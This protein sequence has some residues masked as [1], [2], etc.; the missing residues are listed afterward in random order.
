[1]RCGWSS[2]PVRDGQR[3]GGRYW[4]RR[5]NVP[6]GTLNVEPENV[7]VLQNGV[8]AFYQSGQ[9]RGRQCGD[10]VLLVRADGGHY[11][12]A[13]LD[14]Y[15]NTFL[16]VVDSG[17]FA[18]VC[19][20][21]AFQV[22]FVLSA[23]HTTLD[24]FVHG[25]KQAYEPLQQIFARVILGI[26]LPPE[27]PDLH[28]YAL[29]VLLDPKFSFPTD[30]ADGIVSVEVVSANIRAKGGSQRRM[31]LKPDQQ[32]GPRDFQSMIDQW[33]NTENVPRSIMHLYGV[34]LRFT[35]DRSD[36]GHA[37]EDAVFDL[38]PEPVQ[39]EESAGRST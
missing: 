27:D 11:F 4:I 13:Y 15:T 7:I 17:Q 35:L 30:P 10:R 9:G 14:D 25:G 6:E 34:T 3:R 33:V 19:E 8:A 21:H 39:L 26:E 5:I 29:G 38:V 18:R 12:F 23:D 16:K 20:T 31:V 22:L 2:L 32:L 37:S 36:P 28:P 1:M 24:M